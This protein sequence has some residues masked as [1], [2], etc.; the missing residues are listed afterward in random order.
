[1]N[2][3]AHLRLLTRLRMGGAVPLLSICLHNVDRGK[4]YLF[5]L[6]CMGSCLFVERNLIKLHIEQLLYMFAFPRIIV[7]IRNQKE[8]KMMCLEMTF[9]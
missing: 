5:T 3:T 1:M 6:F 7:I 2:F 8:K 9:P 4:L